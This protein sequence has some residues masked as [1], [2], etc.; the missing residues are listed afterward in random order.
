MATRRLITGVYLA[1]RNGPVLTSINDD[2]LAEFKAS[3]LDE[4]RKMLAGGSTVPADLPW[5]PCTK[6]LGSGV[7]EARVLNGMI[8]LR[9]ELVYTMTAVGSFTIVQRLPANFPKP[10][11]EQVVVAFGMEQQV[12]YRRV[13]VR[14]STDGSIG[15]C[16]DAKITHT[17]MTGAQA[18]AY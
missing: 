12:A 2:S 16:G 4:V 14:F 13:F 6:V 1:N 17:T 18:Y 3:V 9:G 10:P 15:V 5:T 11:Q 8:Q 7:I